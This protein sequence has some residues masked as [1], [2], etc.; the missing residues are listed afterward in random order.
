MGSWLPADSG[1]GSEI[2]ALGLAAGVARPPHLA[3]D[4]STVFT[5]AQLRAVC[6]FL[7]RLQI[8]FC[9]LQ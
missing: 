5:V 3:E 8:L 7:S 2:F 4:A 9:R 6:F 1:L